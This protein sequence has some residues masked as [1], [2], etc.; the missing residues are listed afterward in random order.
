MAARLLASNNY[1]ARKL[2]VLTWVFTGLA[3]GACIWP[4]FG[5]P[6]AFVLAPLGVLWAGAMH[7]YTCRYV[8]TLELDGDAIIVR[9]AALGSPLHRIAVSRLGRRTYHEG[10]GRYGTMASPDAPWITLRVEG[11]RVP[12]VIDTQIEVLDLNGIKAL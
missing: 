6:A 11:F 1:Q 8:T 4:F 10:P 9:T 12:F 2:R 5:D 7:L 3:L